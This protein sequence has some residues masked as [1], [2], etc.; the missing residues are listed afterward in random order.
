MARVEPDYRTAHGNLARRCFHG[1]GVSRLSTTR[2]VPD[3]VARRGETRRVHDALRQDVVSQSVRSDVGPLW[4]LR[5]VDGLERLF[6]ARLAN[7]GA[8][9]GVR[10]AA[11]LVG[12]SGPTVR[13]W[14][15]ALLDTGL[16]WALDERA[17]SAGKY[18]RGQPK[19]YAVDPSLIGACALPVFGG[20]DAEVI[21]RQVETV[22][23]QALR[24]FCERQGARLSVYQATRESGQKDAELD[25]VVEHNGVT[26]AIEVAARD[27]HR[28]KT[29]IARMAGQMAARS[30]AVVSMRAR[31]EKVSIDGR[32]VHL[33]ALHDFLLNLPDATVEAWP[34]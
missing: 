6:V 14:I 2:R 16:L 8:Q 5:E 27:D 31:S 3:H 17:R 28:K 19:L 18:E 32:T 23:A 1:T 20:V 4:G 21:G 13:H 11:Q 12:V 24:V 22:V 7:S 33:I 26:I 34:W 25:F 29:T 30:A 10:D 15:Q 9:L